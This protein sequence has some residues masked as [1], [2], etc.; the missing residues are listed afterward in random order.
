[1][2]EQRGKLTGDDL[3]VAA[4]RRDQ[5]VGKVQERY[6]VAKD[7]AGHQLKEFEERYE[8]V[9]KYRT[10]GTA[11]SWW[12]WQRRIVISRSAIP[13]ARTGWWT[14]PRTEGIRPHTIFKD[15]ESSR[16]NK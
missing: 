15:R 14:L 7:E 13:K 16:R 2:L 4:G 5:I 12:W 9:T 6:G 3:D 1:M 11:D 10:A 8:A